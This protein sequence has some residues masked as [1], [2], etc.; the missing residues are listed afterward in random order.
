[1]YVHICFWS[2]SLSVVVV[3]GSFCVM[4]VSYQL[5]VIVVVFCNWLIVNCRVPVG[6][7]AIGDC[8]FVSWCDQNL[9]RCC[10]A[11]HHLYCNE[12]LE[13]VDLILFLFLFSYI[14]DYSRLNLPFAPVFDAHY[15]GMPDIRT[16]LRITQQLLTQ[17]SAYIS[18]SYNYFC[19]C[20]I[21]SITSCSHQSPYSSNY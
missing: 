5:S 18:C 17:F 2:T 9:Y 16:K 6:R 10:P 1:M 14:S 20:T 11:L 3:W 12:L 8:R 19:L 21:I 4:A 7:L 15:T 13:N